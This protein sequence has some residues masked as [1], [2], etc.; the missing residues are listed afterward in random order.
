[1]NIPRSALPP[2]QRTPSSSFDIRPLRLPVSPF[3]FLGQNLAAGL[4]NVPEAQRQEIRQV[5]EFLD[6]M[7]AELPE[8]KHTEPI[9]LVALARC[10]THH[11]L[12]K[13]FRA[14]LDKM[15][16][17]IARQYETGETGV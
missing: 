6:Q 10:A 7:T 2:G 16:E 14:V 4:S 12:R 15:D 5:I 8:L 11:E 13:L 1:M 9:I 17:I 3:T